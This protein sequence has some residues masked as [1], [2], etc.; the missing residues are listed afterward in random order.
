MYAEHDVMYD[1]R[2]GDTNMDTKNIMI[3]Y[4]VTNDIMAHLTDISLRSNIM[5]Y[6]IAYIQVLAEPWLVL[7]AVSFHREICSETFINPFM[8][9]LVESPEPCTRPGRRITGVDGHNGHIVPRWK[10]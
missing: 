4:D 2:I 5:G 9:W 10:S 1:I 7:P 3:S 6:I 8:N